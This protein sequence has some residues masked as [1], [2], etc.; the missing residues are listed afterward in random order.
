MTEAEIITLVQGA[1]DNTF[2]IV[3]MLFGVVSAY[4]AGLFYFLGRSGFLLKLFGFFVLSWIF[5]YLGFAMIGIEQMTRALIDTMES[6]PERV[7]VAQPLLDIAGIF[8]PGGGR[9]YELGV[10]AGFGFASLIYL[11]LFFLTFVYRWGP[12]HD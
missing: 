9:I 4:L 5:L 11:G 6:L 10:L 1:L 12:R 8:G 3:S 7:T 2:T